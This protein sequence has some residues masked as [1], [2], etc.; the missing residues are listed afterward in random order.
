MA[1]GAQVEAATEADRQKAND[2]DAGSI[3]DEVDYEAMT[4]TN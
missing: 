3:Y 4:L 1:N 2:G